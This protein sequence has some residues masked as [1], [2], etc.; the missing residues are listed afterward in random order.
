MWVQKEMDKN[1]LS[2]ERL[3]EG[4][5]SNISGDHQT[6]PTRPNLDLEFTLGRP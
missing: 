1:C 6:S 2:Y 4:S 5:S 3:S